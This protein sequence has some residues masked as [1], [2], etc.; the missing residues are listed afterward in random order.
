MEIIYIDYSICYILCRNHNSLLYF[1]FTSLH[2]ESPSND[3]QKGI[4]LTPRSWK[5]RLATSSEAEATSS[6]S[7]LVPPSDVSIVVHPAA[8]SPPVQSAST[9]GQLLPPPSLKGHIVKDRDDPGYID[10]TSPSP[11]EAYRS[12]PSF[13]TRTI[14][15]EEEPVSP[16]PSASDGY[17][18]YKSLPDNNTELTTKNVDET[19]V[20]ASQSEEQHSSAPKN[21]DSSPVKQNLLYDVPPSFKSRRSS[22]KETNII[23]S[24]SASNRTE[25]SPDLT[26][27]SPS[28]T[29]T[30]RSAGLTNS[31]S[32]DIPLPKKTRQVRF[33][34]VQSSEDD[35]GSEGMS[36]ASVEIS[37]STM[38]RE[39]KEQLPPQ[40][41]NIDQAVQVFS[42][43]LM[44][45][46]NK[47]QSP[48]GTMPDGEGELWEKLSTDAK[49]APKTKTDPSLVFSV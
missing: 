2:T 3:D 45:G 7:T 12:P 37:Q 46:T 42:K 25:I 47:F 43:F 19:P 6:E 4:Y 28:L 21:N 20:G 5:S 34:S 31:L 48:L 15:E 38:A 8:P 44:E 23:P 27:R 14:P 10:M 24:A 32:Q 11:S 9:S 49:T 35:D 40:V 13:T 22:S 18:S 36:D 29:K 30:E 1:F 41:C 16:P 26:E 39:L 33:V 17:I